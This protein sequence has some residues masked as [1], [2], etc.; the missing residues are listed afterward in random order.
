M[1]ALL[2]KVQTLLFSRVQKFFYLAVGCFL[3][4]E[5]KGACIDWAE[6]IF[7]FELWIMN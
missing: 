2:Q 3:Q 1:I 6:L 7:H 5:D 4:Q